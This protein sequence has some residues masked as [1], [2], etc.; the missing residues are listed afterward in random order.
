MQ[1][2]YM[3]RACGLLVIGMMQK[4][5][6]RNALWNLHKKRA[7]SPPLCPDGSI[8]W[9][10]TVG[11][12]CAECGTRVKKENYMGGTVYYCPGCQKAIKRDLYEILKRQKRKAV[13]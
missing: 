11:Q 7:A 6:F 12:P 1:E 8:P 2:W 13:L 10:H 3:E 4:M 9:R 5:L